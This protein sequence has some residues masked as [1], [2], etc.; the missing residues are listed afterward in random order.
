MESTIT[1]T[2]ESVKGRETR[3]GTVYDVV[4]G[5]K[6]VSTFKQP[7]A[8]EANALQGSTVEATVKT[9]QNGQYTNYTL[10]SL[11]LADAGG[12]TTT[13]STIPVEP[14]KKGWSDEDTAR[15]TRLSC[16]ST[17]FQYAGACGES[18]EA[19]LE[20][21]QRLYGVAMGQREEQPEP[22]QPEPVAVAA[23]P[24]ETSD[25]IPW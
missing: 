7:I 19:A 18:P 9:T 20:L 1:G 12:T 8:E 14:A 10:L 11:K 4:I 3:T 22:E 6:K 15:V 17:A 21:A 13:S 25:G 5:S 23:E 24:T 2:V 16:L